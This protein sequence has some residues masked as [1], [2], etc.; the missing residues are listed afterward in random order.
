MPNIDDFHSDNNETPNQTKI[1]SNWK[2]NNSQKKF[3]VV[4]LFKA[5]LKEL[6]LKIVASSP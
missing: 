4:L 2:N 5:F 1:K 6:K 3:V